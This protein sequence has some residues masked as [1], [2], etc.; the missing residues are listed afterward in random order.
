MCARLRAGRAAGR[1]ESIVVVA[2]GAQDRAGQPI[3]SQ[4]VRDVLRERLGED[5]RVTILGHVQRGGTP[6]AY[7]RWMSTLVG[8]AAA[9][10]VIDAGPDHEP[11]LIGVRQQPGAPH[12]ADGGRRAHQGDPPTDRGR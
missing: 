2:E 10:E 7:D 6:S 5:T 4:R 1:R 11:Q 8:H 12:A 3:T 9:I